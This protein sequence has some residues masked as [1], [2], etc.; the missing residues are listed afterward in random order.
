MAVEHGV[1]MGRRLLLRPTRPA[2]CPTHGRR[3]RFG[4]VVGVHERCDEHRL[5]RLLR[6][7]GRSA[8]RALERHQRTRTEAGV[9]AALQRHGDVGR[10][11]AADHGR[12]LGAVEHAQRD[13][14]VG[15][16]QDVLVD[17]TRRPLRG[18]HE[19]D[20]EAAAALGDVDHAGDELGDLLHQGGEL[21]DDDHQRRRRLVRCDLAASRRGP[22]PGPP[23]PASGGSARRAAR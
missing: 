16:G 21:V 6:G 11:G 9:A 10:L 15:V 4:R 13:P 1:E 7:Q 12:R 14:Q 23:S 2:R 8:E 18:E 5:H 20:A 3:W 22:W 17:R 19:V